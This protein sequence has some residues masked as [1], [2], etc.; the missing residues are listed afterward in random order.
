[1][2]KVFLMLAISVLVQLAAHSQV[3]VGFAGGVSIAKMEGRVHGTGHAG[4]ILSMLV[5]RDLGRNFSFY[6]AVSYV[7]KGT[8]EPHPAGTLIEKQYV[9]LRY[10]ELT[11]NFIYHIGNPDAGNFFLGL[12]PSIDFN[13]PS[14]RVSITDGDK[15]NADI[16]FGPTAEN[17]VRGIDY[18]VNA[19]IGGRT[20][21][22][23]LLQLTW[24]K[25]LRDISPESA[26]STEETKNQYLG[27]QLGFLLNAKK[28]N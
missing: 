26:L 4:A 17:D 5:D 15:T 25:G 18:G 16:L 24:N 10:F 11:T 6:P 23:I 8:T 27:I 3:R 20:K 14:K 28:A 13:L 12:G 7:Q 2:K 1:M 19:V 9:A 21:G 22:G